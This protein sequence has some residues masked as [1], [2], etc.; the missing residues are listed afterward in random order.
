MLMCK[1]M[2]HKSYIFRKY[3][4]LWKMHLN[5]LKHLLKH[6]YGIID[7][8]LAAYAICAVVCMLSVTYSCY[9]GHVTIALCLKEWP[10]FK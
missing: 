1:I 6:I 9:G 2:I 4:S 10:K 8:K 3:H 7:N 5:L